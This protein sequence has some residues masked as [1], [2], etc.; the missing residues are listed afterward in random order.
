VTRGTGIAQL[1]STGWLGVQV[2]A[3]AGNF[4]LHCCP[5][6]NEGSFSGGKAAE[7]EAH[8]SPPTSIPPIYLHGVML[9]WA[10][11]AQGQ[12][13]HIM[14]GLWAEWW[15]Q[16]LAGAGHFSLHCCWC[17]ELT[18]PFIHW[19]PGTFSLWVK[20]PGCEA[21][22]SPPSHAHVKNAWSYTATPHKCLY[23]MV[24]D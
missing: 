8:H 5:V 2:L 18:E 7:T 14:T 15:I 24:L 19:A 3:E 12:F 13:Y 1:Y 6:G 9:S 10:K 23:C 20:R 11:K 21:D 17:Q 16:F 4:S 22:H